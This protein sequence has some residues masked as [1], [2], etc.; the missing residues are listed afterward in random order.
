MIPLAA[1]DA[2]E[3]REVFGLVPRVAVFVYGAD[4][5]HRFCGGDPRILAALNLPPD[6]VE[7]LPVGFSL[8]AAST[9]DLAAEAAR[10]AVLERRASVVRIRFG[11]RRYEVH[12]APLAGGGGVNVIVDVTPTSAPPV[13]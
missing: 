3:L 5:V 9:W 6:G 7:G 11:E 13:W 1:L 10:V 4:L 2:A 8:A 12:V